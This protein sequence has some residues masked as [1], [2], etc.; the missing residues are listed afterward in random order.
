MEASPRPGPNR[1]FFRRLARLVLPA[2]CFAVIAGV[3][4][5]AA[6]TLFGVISERNSAVAAQAALRFREREAEDQII[7]RTPRQIL[8]LDDGSVARYLETA[9]AVLIAGV[10]GE[11]AARI[12]RLASSIPDQTPFI[13]VSS[14]S[15]LVEQS[16]RSLA[17]KPL[18]W[19]R[20][21]AY[22]QGRGVSNLANLLA[23]ILHG[24]DDPSRVA[25]P[26]PLDAIRSGERQGAATAPL[27]AVFDY[28]TGDQAGNIDLHNALCGAL[29]EQDLACQSF[30]AD[31][32]A[33][34][35]TALERLLPESPAAIV[36]L[37]DFA[38]GGAGRERAEA[39]LRDLDVPL[40]KGIRLTEYSQERWEEG[41]DG[42]PAESVYYRVAM[43][44]L[45]G[46][47]QAAVLAVSEAPR[48]DPVSGIE[49]RVTTPVPA[50]VRSV[51]RRLAR[52]TDLRETDNRDKRV[53]IVYYNHP[54]GRHNIGA[55]NLDVPQSLLEI[56]KRLD[57]EGYTVGELPESA[58][59]LLR[60]IQERAVNLPE[61]NEVLRGLWQAGLGFSDR[62]Y[63]DWLETQPEFVRVELREGPLGALRLRVDAALAAQDVERAENLV[64]TTLQDAAFVIEGAP[65][66]YHERAEALLD[67]LQEVYLEHIRG[68]ADRTQLDSLTKAL[69]NQGIEGLRGWGEVPGSVMT[70][71]G[72]FVFP[73]LR[74]GNVILAPQ[75]PRGWEVNEE[76][77]HANL[78][79]PPTHQY[80]AFYH[81]LHRDFEPHAMIH[82]GRHSTYEFLP[83]KRV[84]LGATDYPRLVAG[85][86]PGLYPYIVDGVGEGLQAK[87]RGLAV[88]VD[89]LTP[90][91]QATPYY[92][93]L[94]S[95]RQLVESFESADPSEAG[96]I[97]RAQ[98]FER[99]KA[100]V[101]ALG[102]REALVAELEA[103]HGGGEVIEFESIDPDLLVHEAGHF[104]TELQED[105]MPL[106]LHVFGRPWTEEALATMLESMGDD[107]ARASLAGSPKAEMDALVAGLEGRYVVPG[108]GNDPL[109]SPDSL[110][111]GRNF[112]A[113]DSSL[114]PNSIA[115]DIGSAMAQEKPARDGNEAVVLWASDTVRD[116]GVMMAFGLELLGV[117]PV[118][119]SRGIVTGLE[120]LPLKSGRERRD[121]TFVASGLFRD[122]YGQQMK[123]LDKAVLLALDGAAQTIAA[124]FP[125]YAEALE[126]TL[127]PLGELRNPGRDSLT[128]NA[129]ARSWVS[130]LRDQNRSDG[131][132]GRLA[133]LRL[134]APAPG[135]YSAG[136]NRLAERSGAWSDR[137]QLAQTYI[138]R[139]GH[140]YGEGIDGIPRQDQFRKR[141]GDVSSS[142][143]GRASNLYGLVDNNDAYD[144]LG[145]LNLAVETLSGTPARGFVVDVSD[146]QTPAMTPLATA[147][148]QELRSRQLNPAWIEALMVHGYAGA[149]TMNSAFFENLWGWE[150]TDPTLFADTIWEEAKA[151]YVDDR[152]D[153]GLQ[154]FL[155]DPTRQPVKANMLAIMLVAAYRGFWEADEATVS[156]LAE[157]FARVV[158]T[159]G[160]PG[161]GHTQPD[162]PMLDW[163]TEKVPA[164][165]AEQLTAIR[166]AARGPAAA[167]TAV[168]EMIR[169]LQPVTEASGSEAR[170]TA[171][172]LGLLVL[173]L[174]GSGILRGWRTPS[175]LT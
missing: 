112:F 76:V 107:G 39:A 67:Q 164:D 161:S 11:D 73:H 43:P 53:A 58:D 75:P 102:I 57:R 130:D 171:L 74:F 2:C 155:D 174:L 89:H 47:G 27:V 134:F 157:A 163:V 91:L 98:A 9:D 40:L 7:L 173:L 109:R 113:L 104:L 103:E 126:Y 142:Y 65:A 80:L 83:G 101:E 62:A 23:F 143:L 132:A 137:S 135:R 69:Q 45:S 117:R 17:G 97:P 153:L 50:E 64:R 92:D 116:G 108:K 36:M 93:E 151:I 129:V 124:Q 105:F 52:W 136:V 175:S 125:E 139:I 90:P 168:P 152:Y 120:R 140:A 30:F 156:N 100:Q 14:A 44:E 4:N 70:V 149:R 34:S 95:L 16:K 141:L 115:W 54:P 170:G 38:V 31:W 59:D 72:G 51:S 56:L 21:N 158:A 160:L 106:G 19:D 1:R 121:V 84:G 172:M 127:A 144:Y 77:L 169:E 71:E 41:A 42:L 114:V 20:A 10:F 118:W 60:R 159:A 46:A 138:A 110:P 79:V 55:D 33:P 18:L 8:A 3:E 111:T 128:D 165:L 147:I 123:L 150:A 133:S 24:E 88:I 49:V 145:G 99:I 63:R 15:T 29:V 25:P 32:G 154:E 166:D 119:N 146:P 162:H 94:L 85:D 35:A 68:G 78:S 13:A 86:T 26:Q 131:R 28:E 82:L 37:Q 5:A 61:N 148:L 22:W 48:I 6:T 96:D 12:G 87:R 66:R 167:N 81:W 122:L